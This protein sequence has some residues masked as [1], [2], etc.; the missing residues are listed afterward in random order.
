MKKEKGKIFSN[1]KCIDVIYEGDRII[2]QKSSEMLEFSETWKIENFFKGYIPELRA[3]TPELSINEKSLLF[4]LSI[5]VGYTDCCI[6]FDNGDC[7]NIGDMVKISGMCKTIVYDTLIKLI[8]KDIIYKGKNS[9]E[10]QYFINPWLFCKGNR[11]N[12]VLKTMFKN[13]KIR[14]LNQIW[15][16]I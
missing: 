6:K 7:L 4:C 8:R 10:S 14:V 2:R 5:Y 9:Y 16:N 13:Y 12:K 15:D 3:I 11:I 1:G